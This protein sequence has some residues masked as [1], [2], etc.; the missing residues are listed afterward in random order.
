[1]TWTTFAYEFADKDR[2]QEFRHL[3][4]DSLKE[5]LRDMKRIDV[6][7]GLCA[8][9]CDSYSI[10]V[11]FQNLIVQK[12]ATYVNT[13]PQEK[14]YLH[15]DKPY[16]STQED[17]WFKAYIVSAFDPEIPPL[18]EIV[19][20][21]LLDPTGYVVANQKI[22]LRQQGGA[23]HF[24]L[25]DT[26]PPGTYSIR[27]YTRWNLNF[28]ESLLF[29]KSFRLLDPRIS[30][31][32]DLMHESTV[33]LSFFPEGGDLL[34]N[35][36]TIVGF[37]AVNNAG[38]GVETEGQ[39]LDESGK[40]ITSFKSI[41]A[42]MGKFIIV[43]ASEKKYTARITHEG[44]SISFS[45]PE[46]KNSGYVIKATHSFK[47]K[48]VI[49]GVY[50]THVNLDG[51]F[52]LGHQNG[53][54]FLRVLTGSKG[55]S[56][57]ITKTDFSDGICHLTFFD[58]KG[59]PRSERILVVRLPSSVS[60]IELKGSKIYNKRDQVSL[61]VKPTKLE[62]TA[63]L[64]LSVSITP[65]AEVIVPEFGQNI[66]NYLW[67]TSDL[68]G[69]IE[70]PEYYFSA[71][72]NAYNALEA[73][74]LT[75]GWRRFVWEDVLQVDNLTIDYLPQK[76]LTIEGKITSSIR[77]SKG[78]QGKVSLSIIDEDFSFLES[79]TNEQGEFLF[80]NIEIYDSAHLI[81]E[82]KRIARNKELKSDVTLSLFSDDLPVFST[83]GVPSYSATT[84]IEPYLD[85]MA[86][87]LEI[88]SAFR[89]DESVIILDEVEIEGVDETKR[90]EDFRKYGMLYGT[91]SNRLVM[92][93][94][95][96]A[97]TGLSIFDV[98]QSRIPGVRVVG[99]FP[100][101][102]VIIRTPSSFSGGNQ[103]A[104]YLL[105]G[106]PV[107]AS[108]MGS[109]SP[110]DVA[111]IDVLKG[112]RTN[113]YGPQAFNG[114][115]AVYTKR[116]TSRNSARVPASKNI[117]KVAYQGFSVAKEF[118]APDY[119]IQSYASA[120]P[121]YRTT[122]YWNPEITVTQDTAIIEFFT[123]DQTGTF[124]LILEGITAT[125]EPIYLRDEIL[126]K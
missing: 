117:L 59:I 97:I 102:A 43:P 23:G 67:L 120:K 110:E 82:G 103:Q 118:Y 35:V 37:K 125:G 78:V 95:N 20:V 104:F 1:M 11:N 32:T 29:T 64:N 100:N 96:A 30:S 5:I 40:V 89:L 123:S 8:L 41:K 126:V 12:L 55:I 39:V 101:Q 24:Y 73:L 84:E 83:G 116:G 72:S 3:F 46:V 107:D 91:P 42:G 98:V 25:S 92:D 81:L 113:I 38:L 108:T 6:W 48:Q 27:A 22:K 74:M 94:V 13:F 49:L 21:D 44:K 9:L 4:C 69:P 65:K 93:S 71:T 52:L 63:F 10:A 14:V 79:E 33:K 86:Q 88:D 58:G 111:F 106:V 51:G 28:E 56:A 26:L 50:G 47:S 87:N 66:K 62:G 36:P 77:K 16:Y 80:E 76:S 34:A 112:P 121:D 45:L 19:E 57:I 2:I 61:R 122:L 115:F 15:L 31:S 7:I 68:K 17:L 18:S 105:D 54:E 119:S 90:I 53:K 124:D 114:V 70:D 60:P 99:G 75:Q 85:R 109:V